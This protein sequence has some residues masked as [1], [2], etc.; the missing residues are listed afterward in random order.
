[1]VLAR[2]V[3]IPLGWDLGMGWLDDAPELEVAYVKNY[4]GMTV[5]FGFPSTNPP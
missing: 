3:D 1:M 5:S 4:Q 2:T